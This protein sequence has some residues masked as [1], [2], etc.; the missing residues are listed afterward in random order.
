MKCQGLGSW[1][2]EQN[3][4]EYYFNDGIALKKK[5]T[6][7][8]YQSLSIEIQAYEDGDKLETFH[9]DDPSST[10]NEMWVGDV[11]S[12]PAGEL[13]FHSNGDL[14]IDLVKAQIAKLPKD[15]AR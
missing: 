6:D 4:F 10:E 1:E 8:K 13:Y 2:Y 14:N 7:N 3:V 11:K 15:F 12:H 5:M 9:Q